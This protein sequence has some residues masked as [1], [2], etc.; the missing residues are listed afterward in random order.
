MESI[1]K[2]KKLRPWQSVLFVVLSAFMTG[3]AWRAR[4]DHGWGSFKGM[5]M[6]AFVV[7]ILIITFFPYKKKINGELFPLVI[8]MTAL[9]NAGYGTFNSQMTGILYS[10]SP[11][12]MEELS[13]NISPLSGIGIMLIL[14]F[15]WAPFLC[16]FI[17]Y[18]FSDKK[19]KWW[20]L[21]IT[22]ALF[23]AIDYLCRATVSHLI[24]KAINPQAVSCFANSLTEAGK[25]M[26]PYE[27]YMS[28][29]S[30]ISFGKKFPYG[31][32]YYQ[33]I[34]CISS[35]L[36]TLAV[37]IYTRFFV[38]DK[39]GARIQLATCIGLGVSITAADLCIFV[40]RGGFRN[41][42]TP[43]EWLTGWSCW[44]YFTGFLFGLI[45]AI[46]VLAVTK[47]VS[48]KEENLQPSRLIPDIKP[49][50]FIWNFAP[51]MCFVTA[52]TL[53]IPISLRLT[54]EPDLIFRNVN[55]ENEEDLIPYLAVIG[56][57]ALIYPALSF[58][59]KE[60]EN[61]LA[62]YSCTRTML[63]A[64]WGIL[65]VSYLCL[66]TG[67]LVHG[68]ASDYDILTY[69]STVIVTVGI[70]ILLNGTKEKEKA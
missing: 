56:V 21:L 11:D 15:G 45:T 39:K 55:F 9:T 47:G 10:N 12:G 46:I 27:A 5:A 69:I 52:V 44:E 48:T 1:L 4:G 41:T 57:L 29:F 70:I 14:G 25:D 28:H 42:L 35:A 68:N 2:E 16:T 19:R 51:F 59:K 34:E 37:F 8:L 26:T 31:R 40:A 33:S 38:R 3:F 66:G 63:P 18:Y 49:L 58:T 7:V 43:P 6:V 54:D 23:Y 64:F 36:G 13:C 53:I 32:N 65:S 20:Q 17:G 30:N 22:I 60:R 24:I 62:I 67:P 50:R 61:P